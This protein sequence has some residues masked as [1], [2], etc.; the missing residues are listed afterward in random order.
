MMMVSMSVLALPGALQRLRQGAEILLGLRQVS[1][2]QILLQRT[3]RLL[4]AVRR[5]RI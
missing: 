2:L 5:A 3:E 4:D 1:R